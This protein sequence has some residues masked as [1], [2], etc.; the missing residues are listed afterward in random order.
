MRRDQ[1]DKVILVCKWQGRSD[2]FFGKYK[3]FETGKWLKI[4]GGAFPPAFDTKEKALMFAKEWYEQV[5]AEHRAQVAGAKPRP[6]ATWDDICDAYIAE[7]KARMRG[8]PSTR[9][10]AITLTN[11]SLRRGILASGKPSENDENR[12]LV[13]LRALAIQNIAQ[14][15]KPYRARKPMTVRNIAKHLRYLFKFAVRSK[16]IPGLT[17]NPTQGDEFRDELKGLVARVEPREWL[18]PIESFTK[19]VSCPKVPANRRI[20]Y[21]VL[22]LAGLRPGELAGLQV[23][24]LLRDGDVRFFSIEQQFTY[25]RSKGA[26]GAIDTPKTKWARRSVPLHPALVEPLD[27]WLS[28][29][30][31][32]W[33]G[34]DP[35]NEDFVFPASDGMPRRPHDADV[36]R[37]DL[38]AA[39]CPTKFNGEPLTPYSLRHLFSTLLTECHAHDAAHDRLMGHRPK[40]TKTL[41]YSAKL[42]TF[43]A[44]EIA[45]IPFKLPAE[46]STTATQ[47]AT[48]EDGEQGQPAVAPSS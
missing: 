27:A 34:R 43:L 26:K 29:G 37:R 13:W 21:L 6:D 14:P 36:F 30:W 47:R 9:H 3:S 46:P 44:P 41:N 8:K 24:H 1:P 38:T 35:K 20:A 5:E 4:P 15:G 17:A 7:V 33:V 40:D 39:D 32:G 31:K 28:T 16:L 11:A 48:A 42:L 19:L 10:E 2:R 12:C 45:R 22:G 23:R 25:T 18:L